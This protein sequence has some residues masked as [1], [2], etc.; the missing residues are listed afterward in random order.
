L[1]QRQQ[2]RNALVFLAV[3]LF[4]LFA[5][6]GVYQILY[7]IH[8]WNPQCSLRGKDGKVIWSRTG[9]DLTT[10][11]EIKDYVI[12]AETTRGETCTVIAVRQWYKVKS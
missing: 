9:P 2:L 3:A 6:T 12:W 4:L 11:E 7:P 10:A 5:G 1:I 8:H